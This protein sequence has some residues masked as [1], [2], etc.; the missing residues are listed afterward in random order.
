[1]VHNLK[2]LVAVSR[3][4][5]ADTLKSLLENMDGWNIETDLCKDNASLHERIIYGLP[6]AVF[7]DSKINIRACIESTHKIL[8]SEHNPVFFL[9]AD[10][11]P[12]KDIIHAFRSGISDYLKK[13]DLTKSSL[14]RLLNFS[15]R[16]HQGLFPD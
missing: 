1:M 2:I 13:K 14:S 7:L 10:T 5:E 12:E 6:D 15:E 3:Q 11:M 16:V 4:Q 9:L 8:A